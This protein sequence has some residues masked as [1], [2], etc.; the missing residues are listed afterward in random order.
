MKV[1]SQLFERSLIARIGVAMAIIA[2]VVVAGMGTSVIIAETIRGSA[3]AINIAGSLRMQSYRIAGQV[4]LAQ[5]EPGP[6]HR[7]QL[8]QDIE[9][10][11]RSLASPALSLASLGKSAKVAA[12]RQKVEMGWTRQ[13]RPKIAAIAAQMSDAPRQKLVVDN[14][15]L[16][17]QVDDFVGNINEFVKQLERDTEARI[18]FLSIALGLALFI[19]L[20]VV[21]FTMYVLHTEILTP[22]RDLLQLTANV[23]R[24]KLDERTEHT[25]PDELGRL[26]QAFNL[27]T[28]DLAVLYRG[29]EERVAEKTAHLERS[30]RSLELLYQTI[31]RLYD[32]PILPDT[33][34][35]L[36]KD[37]ET[38]LGVG[39]G[40]VCLT[41]EGGIDR[42]EVL[43]TT[44][45][46]ESS[47]RAFCE[48]SDCRTCFGDGTLRERDLAGDRVLSLP[49]RDTEHQ[50]GVLQL[51]IPRAL[52]LENWQMQ[53]LEALCRHIGIAI[54]TARRIE[55][56]RRLSLLE[57]RSVIAR[58]LHD[59]LAQSLSY[60]K[61]QV[62]RLQGA[63]AHYDNAEQSAAILDELR[64]GLNGA[65]RQLR[66]LLT[67]FRLR[68][69]GGS[70]IATL[71]QTAIEF[72]HR[73]NLTIQ[74]DTQLAGCR[75]TPNEEIHLLQ[76]VREALSNV[77]HHANAKH[78][79]VGVVYGADETIHATI[80][81]DGVGIGEG[82]SARSH[83]GVTIMRER[84][85]SLGGTV[86]VAR[87]ARGGTRVSLQF[88][89]GAQGR[90]RLS[91]SGKITR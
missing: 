64:D 7:D 76:V 23:R 6:Q 27:M 31:S 75:L 52:A 91:Q 40:S 73:G 26:G 21:F 60:M 39:H 87:L 79:K 67:T 89:P 32:Q 86:S 8:L 90:Q 4:L 37:L 43:A 50:Y 54:G 77:V 65:Y 61:I 38:V 24:G 85:H 70:L 55:Q 80:E 42:A 16:L 59:S 62:S 41:H 46:E 33:Y 44:L 14:A 81:D 47:E 18:R 13:I 83:Y 84:A 28:A 36:L 51:K 45:S 88:T 25:G 57:E 17:G 69:E 34:R 20:A 19:T 68:I 58:E 1:V 5:S 82:E 56:N 66:E 29:L 22:L 2:T 3:E 48:A 15:A 30:N 10:F 72:E 49:L 63:I 53:L 9:M 11:E 35:I 12:A 78:V 74:L 71:K